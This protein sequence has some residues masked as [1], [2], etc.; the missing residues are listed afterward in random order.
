MLDGFLV[1]SQNI[2][3][4]FFMKA[5]IWPLFRYE[6]C[7]GLLQIPKSKAPNTTYEADSVEHFIEGI[8]IVIDLTTQMSTGRVS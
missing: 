5:L 6:D 1:N 3:K 7:Y 4:C 8:D 2:R